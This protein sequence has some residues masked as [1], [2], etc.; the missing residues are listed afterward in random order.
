MAKAQLTD[1]LRAEYQSLFDTCR[2]LD[3]AKVDTV[4][5]LI[6]AS[7]ERYQQLSDVSGV[8]WHFIGGVHMLEAS[9]DFGRHLYNGD[10][11]E[12]RT[13]NFPPGRP[14]EGEP[15]FSFEFSAMHA[16]QDEGVVNWTDWSIPGM[17]F[18]WEAYNGFGYRFHGVNSPYLWGGSQHYTKGLFFPD[19]VFNPERVSAAIGVAVILRSMVD[20][21]LVDLTASA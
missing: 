16:L 2:V 15:P 17:L 9:C 20:R 19:H 4:V 12:R 8:P 3:A 11:L 5:N 18:K 6:N 13:V 10:H 1:E 7:Q 14:R 21:R